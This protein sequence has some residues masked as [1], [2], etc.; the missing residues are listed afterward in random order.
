MRTRKCI[1]VGW[2]VVAQLRLSI[3]RAPVVLQSQ[4]I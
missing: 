1:G 2:T 3:N 4:T